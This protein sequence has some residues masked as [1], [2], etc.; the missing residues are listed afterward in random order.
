MDE[1]K[2]I[3]LTIEG[4]TKL[5]KEQIRLLHIERVQVVEELKAAR[6]Q[7][8]LSEN[9]DYDA[10]RDRQARV[11]ATIKE[12]DYVLTNFEL[13]DLDE[14]A[15]REQLQEELENLRE[16]KSLVNDEILEAKKNGVGDDNIE[17]FEICDKLA[18]IGTRI[19]T[20]EYALKN[21]TTKKSSKK[22]VK[23]GSKVVILTLDEEE[24]EEYTI[25]GTVEADPINGKISNETPLAMA[26]LERKVG[27]IVTVFVGHPYKVEIKKID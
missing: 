10:A 5:E 13:I 18:E 11:E 16:E 22:T 20:I 25:V 3:A 6:S 9:A 12:N 8:D 27:D 17:L 23:L 1:N 15:S 2:V 7:G 24:E 21:E 14:K 19:R 26:L 4:L